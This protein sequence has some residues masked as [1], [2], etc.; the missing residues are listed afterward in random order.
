M[1]SSNESTHHWWMTAVYEI[2]QKN[3]FSTVKQKNAQMQQIAEV[4]FGAAVART[5]HCNPH[6]LTPHPV[7]CL[8]V[9]EKSI[10][11]SLRLICLNWF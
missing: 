6:E 2:A 1:Y 10:E 9:V 8:V 7:W 11:P 4:N 3:N 5:L